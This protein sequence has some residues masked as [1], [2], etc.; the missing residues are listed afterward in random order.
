MVC[1]SIVYHN[2]LWLTIGTGFMGAAALLLNT[3]IS[4]TD[5]AYKMRRPSGQDFPGSSL[6]FGECHPFEIRS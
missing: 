3:A 1:C 4:Q 5:T 6:C 2:I